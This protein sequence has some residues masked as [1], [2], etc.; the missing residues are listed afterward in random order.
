ASGQMRLRL[1]IP[2]ACAL[3]PWLLLPVHSQ[4]AEQLPPKVK[5]F[6]GKYCL[7]CH[8][9]A[10]AK[11]KLSLE[12]LAP[13]FELPAWVHVHDRLQTENMPPEEMPQP[14]PAERAE[15][16]KYLS[17]KLT[18]AAALRQKTEGRVLLRRMNRREYETTL[19]D[20]LGITTPLQ[21]LL[22]EDN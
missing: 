9:S 1:L 8:D 16:V 20:L 19:H 13:Q 14:S 18:A 22:P 12:S 2:L 5:T 7:D 10:T 6:F 15:I 3:L 21:T 4:G 17:E 11:A